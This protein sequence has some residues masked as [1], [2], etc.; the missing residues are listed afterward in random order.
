M[1]GKKL[2]FIHAFNR[3]WGKVIEDFV[4]S[5]ESKEDYLNKG[6]NCYSKGWEN[7]FWCFVIYQI[8]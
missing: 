5:F 6:R 2:W 8:Q 3:L 1:A 7:S 4:S